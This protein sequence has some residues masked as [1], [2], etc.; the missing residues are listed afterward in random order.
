MEPLQLVLVPAANSYI[1]PIVLAMVGLAVGLLLGA[2]LRRKLSEQKVRAT[3]DEAKRLVEDAQR[4]AT[5]IVSQ[6]E[7][8]TQRKQI[9][10]ERKFERDLQ[11]RRVEI[12][13]IEGRIKRREEH[14]DQRE[15]QI[16]RR[17]QSLTDKERRLDSR[18][19]EV[20]NAK[21]DIDSLKR[22]LIAKCEEISG[23]T[24]EQA[25]KML[26]EQLDTELHQEQAAAVRRV[27]NETR[28]IAEKKARQ[29]I[30]L[31]IQ[32]CATDQVSETTVSVVHLPNDE[33]KG[34]IIGREGRNIR[35]LEQLTG[36]NIIVDDTPEAVV[37]SC[38]DPLRREVARLTL[39]K[40]ISDGRIH[41][42]RVEELVEKGERELQESIRQ[43][44]EAA[45]AELGIFDIHAELVKLLGRLKY[46]TSYGQNVLRH[47]VECAHVAGILASEVGIDPVM[48]KRAA[49]LHDIGKAVSSEMEGT[50]TAIGADLARKYNEP[51]AVV[52]AIESH[53][54]EVEP[55]T[56]VAVLIQ[57]A[58]AISASR[59]GARRETL[60]SYIKRLEALEAIANSF[61]GVAKSFAIQAGR[62]IRIAV[63]PEK[64]NDNECSKLARDVTKRVESEL[65][66]PGQIKIV[67]LRETRSVEYAR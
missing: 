21:K 7:A 39:E 60:E 25:K 62:E 51:N 63:E 41:P 2:L 53:H 30:T 32:K 43:A 37:I 18:L 24:T 49:L 47:V 42:A 48:T 33:M 4:Q 46:R 29:I 23:L 64:L 52:H 38:F 10:R 67:V 14:I 20:E 66:Y 3:E 22:T 61:E 13:R 28:E 15:E 65:Q 40:L 35:T 56:L 12:D 16:S 36:V 11:K 5:E 26:L 58:D 8:E 55:R 1:L 45:C 34:R 54:G 6:T 31:A 50:H 59:P 9:E 19:G 17:E 27:E 44:G 57:A